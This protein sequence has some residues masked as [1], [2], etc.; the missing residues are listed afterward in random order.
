MRLILHAGTHKTGT[1]TIQRVL[2]DHRDALRSQGALYPD[3]T[4]WFGGSSTG[5]HALAHAIAS[6]E[7][8][9]LAT[10]RAFL[11]GVA[12]QARP[13]ETVLL[14]AEPVYRHRLD[15]A[16]GGWWRRHRAYLSELASELTSAG[17]DPEVVLVFRRRDEFVESVYH[18]RV[19]R[20]F[21]RP[22]EHLLDNADRLLDYDRQLHVFRAAFPHVRALDYADLAGGD[23]VGSFLRA[24]G[25]EP[26]AMDVGHWERR[27]TDARL[28]LWMAACYREDPHEELIA[29]RRR[30]SKSPSCDRLFDDF[31]QVTLWADRAQR[32][33]LLDSYGD[34]EPIDDP[35]ASAVLTPTIEARIDAAFD[36]YLVAKGLSPTGRSARRP[37]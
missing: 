1:S 16:E 32:R 15:S 36:E 31:G 24:L 12:E 11:A 18:E 6:Q 3:S 13:G 33:E 30:F 14:S 22:F 20:G 19:S 25:F 17:F 5:H 9:V 2:Y 10:A 4:A 8:E 29:L 35:R 28:S 27:S 34:H 7:P 23:I 37:A 26:P 21:G